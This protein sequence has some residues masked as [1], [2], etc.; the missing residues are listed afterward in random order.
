ELEAALVDPVDDL[1]ADGRPCEWAGVPPLR[2]RRPHRGEELLYIGDMRIGDSKLG[3][4]RR[5]LG[6][7]LAVAAGH[8]EPGERLAEMSGV[9]NFTLGRS[10]LAVDPGAGRLRV[11]RE[12]R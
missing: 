3:A 10:G 7:D 12:V 6:A 2:N 8:L 1:G 9:G 5:L 4:E 11:C